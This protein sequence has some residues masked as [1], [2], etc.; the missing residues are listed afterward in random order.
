VREFLVTL[1]CGR[2]YVVKAERVKWAG[3]YLAL[4]TEPPSVGDADPFAGV[5]AMF[6]GRQVAV[7]VIRDHLV[8]EEMGEPVDPDHV[9]S[10]AQSDIPF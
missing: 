9:A 1:R 6:D 5:V 3:G 2:R 8:S 4:V 10:D 7:V